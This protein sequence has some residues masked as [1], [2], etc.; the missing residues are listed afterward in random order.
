MDGFSIPFPVH[1][2]TVFEGNLFL[3]TSHGIRV[4]SSNGESKVYTAEDGLEAASFVSVEASPNALYA[5]SQQGAVA[6][7]SKG[8]S[9]F[10]IINRSFLEQ[11]KQAI[12]ALTLIS[13]DILVIAFRSRLAFFNL[14]TEEFLITLSK[15]GDVSLEGKSPTAIA[16]YND[17]LYV[18]VEDVVYVRKMEWD[19]LKNDRLF[20]DPTSWK[21]IK[22][23]EFVGAIALDSQGKLKT[24]SQKGTYVFGESLELAAAEDTSKLIVNGKPLNMALLRKGDTS[25]VSWVIPEGNGFFFAGSQFV[26]YGNRTSVKD[27]T[28]WLAYQL[29]PVYEVTTLPNGGIIASGNNSMLS[30]VEGAGLVF[31][32]PMPTNSI[33]WSNSFDGPNHL[34]KTLSVLPQGQMYYG[35]WGYG[36]TVFENYKSPEIQSLILATSGSCLENY[37]ENYLVSASA[38]PAPDSSGFLVSYWGKEHYGLAFV[39]LYG[40]VLCA[41]AV[42]TTPIAGAMVARKVEGGSD[43]EVFVSSGTTAALNGTGSIDKFILEPPSRSGFSLRII[44]K[45]SISTPEKGFVLDMAFDKENRLWGITYSNIAFLESEDML[46]TPHRISQFSASAF[47]AIAIDP[48]G[49]PW[50][51]SNGQGVF[52]LQRKNNSADT[53]AAKK[54]TTRDGLLSENVYDIALDSVT[55]SIWFAQDLGLSRLQ[56]NDLRT[57]NGFMTDSS[58]KEVVVYPNPYRPKIHQKV[59]FDYV[60]EKAHIS[61]LNAGGKL[62]RSFSGEDLE[63]GKA[64]W[65][66]MDASGRLVAPG[67]YHYFIKKGNKKKKGRLLIVH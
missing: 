4:V 11:G 5:I 53:L 41:P 43:W 33:G 34:M 18:G 46:R 30:Y 63:G 37:L 26:G 17:S 54:I 40:D 27:Y 64:E 58:S 7:F 48:Q 47:S 56:R 21:K 35:I 8:S 51:S 6:R 55:G 16:A 44:D 38:I 60:S 19:N 52:R 31:S 29:G 25:K 59:V 39:N 24:R 15:I 62:V 57:A 61:I 36:G 23:N 22:V 32:N 28:P 50:V 9:S 12:P 13:S 45:K 65:D 42:G 10:E 14:E 2:A 66:G 1:D 67:V 20:A 49:N 3:A